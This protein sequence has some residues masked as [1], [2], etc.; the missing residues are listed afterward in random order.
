[1]KTAFFLILL[2][3]F[4][5]MAEDCNRYEIYSVDHP[6]GKMVIKLDKKTGKTYDLIFIKEGCGWVPLPDTLISYEHYLNMLN[7]RN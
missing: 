2:S 7:R 4:C 5:A 6:K 3:I 1:M